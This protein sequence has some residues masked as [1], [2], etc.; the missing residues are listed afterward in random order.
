MDGHS[1]CPERL[2]VVLLCCLLVDLRLLLGRLRLQYM[3]RILVHRIQVLLLRRHRD[4]DL[5]SV[6]GNLH[7]TEVGGNLVVALR[8]PRH[9]V[10]VR[11]LDSNVSRVSRSLA[12]LAHSINVQHSNVGWRQKKVLEEGCDHVPW[13][14]LKCRS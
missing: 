12:G 13:L 11:E 1:L 2:V 4:L 14:K 3:N 9:V 5:G 7:D 8:P 10:Y 6:L